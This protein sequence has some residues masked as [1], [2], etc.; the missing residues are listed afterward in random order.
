MKF[1]DGIISNG[2]MVFSKG[3]ALADVSCGFSIVSPA[4]ENAPLSFLAQHETELRTFL[5]NLAPDERLQIRWSQDGDFSAPLKS[6]YEDT[7]E[8]A[9][10]EWSRHQRNSK[11]VLNSELQEAGRLRSESSS[12][13]LL[14]KNVELGRGFSKDQAASLEAVSQGFQLHERSL[15][16]MLKRLGGELSLIHI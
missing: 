5:Q 4:L 6:Y 16:D 14:K 13:F 12:V 3:H 9:D 7:E 15:R 11:F 8:L 10:S 1:N 2:L